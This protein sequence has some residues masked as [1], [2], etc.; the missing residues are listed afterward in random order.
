VARRFAVARA[1]GPAPLALQV[2]VARVVGPAPLALQVA[3]ARV[4]GPAPLALQV[5]VAWAV[6]PALLAGDPVRGRTRIERALAEPGR[7]STPA[8]RA[9]ASRSAQR[10][11]ITIGLLARAAQEHEAGQAVWVAE[12]LAV[13]PLTAK[14]LA[15]HSRT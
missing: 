14:L 1:V 7:H 12:H 4:V 15:A 5:A 2:A 10:Q 6:G 9:A 3:V 8:V 13:L 11:P